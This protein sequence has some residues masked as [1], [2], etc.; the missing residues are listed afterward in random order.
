MAPSVRIQSV[1]MGKTQGQEHEAAGP[2]AP[3]DKTQREDRGRL[4]DVRVH[5]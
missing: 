5:L 2:I 3:A 1:V 4:E